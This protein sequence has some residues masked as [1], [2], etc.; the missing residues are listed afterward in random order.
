MHQWFSEL[1]KT[2]P[3]ANILL[4]D[5]LS[6]EERSIE[7]KPRSD[8]GHKASAEKYAATHLRLSEFGIEEW[9]ARFLNLLHENRA[10][11][12]VGSFH[13]TSFIFV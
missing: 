9:T 13:Q 8:R 11:K 3:N 7:V 1:N 6:P 5:H 10:V 4:Y 2:I 12:Q